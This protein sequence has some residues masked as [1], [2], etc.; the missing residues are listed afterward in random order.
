MGNNF[1]E[2]DN[3]DFS[4]AEIIMGKPVKYRVKGKDFMGTFEGD[5]RYKDFLALRNALF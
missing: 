2:N 4:I 1:G 5:R 3:Q